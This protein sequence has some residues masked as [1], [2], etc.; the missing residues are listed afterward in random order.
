MIVR[1]S[2]VRVIGGLTSRSVSILGFL[3]AGEGE[4]VSYEDLR[5]PE[6]SESLNGRDTASSAYLEV[7]VRAS[8]SVMKSA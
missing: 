5:V 7:D 2:G 8:T 1:L 3:A 4:W 6:V